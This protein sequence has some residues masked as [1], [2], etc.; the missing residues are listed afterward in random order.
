MGG[1]SW[2]MRSVLALVCLALAAHASIEDE[3]MGGVASAGM[4]EAENMMEVA[5]SNMHAR[6]EAMAQRA[7]E[8]M[9]GD[10]AEAVPRGKGVK[11]YDRTF[12]PEPGEEIT[13]DVVTAGDAIPVEIVAPPKQVAIPLKKLKKH[14]SPP[15]SFM[16]NLRSR[17]GKMR[18]KMMHKMRKMWGRKPRWIKMGH[19]GRHVHRRQMAKM[20]LRKALFKQC[21]EAKGMCPAHPCPMRIAKCLMKRTDE[22]STG[23]SSF[24]Q[25]L[26][27]LRKKRQ[28]ARRAFRAARRHCRKKFR[29]E[30][31]RKWSCVRRARKQKWRSMRSVWSSLRQASAPGPKSKAKAEDEFGIAKAKRVFEAKMAELK[32]FSKS[33]GKESKATLKA[34]KPAAGCKADADCQTGGDM[35]GYCKANGDCHCSAPFFGTN[36]KTCSLT[37][38][39]T[40]KT[41][42]CRDDADCQAGGDTKAYCKTPKANHH[43][44]PGNG[45]CRCGTGFSGTT[46]CHKTSEP[47][48]A[49][50]EK[51]SM[52]EG[53]PAWITGDVEEPKGEKDMGGWVM[54]AY[55]PEQQSRLNVD[56]MGRP[57]KKEKAAAKEE[58][59]EKAEEKTPSAELI[60]TTTAAVEKPVRSF[61]HMHF[62]WL[63][64]G[65]AL[66][67][68]VIGAVVTLKAR[69]RQQSLELRAVYGQ[70]MSE[71]KT[72]P[73][74][75]TAQAQ[76]LVAHEGPADSQV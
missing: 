13:V 73:M 65:L 38:T 7:N 11:S 17:L 39:P 24:L 30:K 41:P 4:A 63:F 28:A 43:T 12:H 34:G 71:P 3:I 31:R 67:I 60:S 46:S 25:S 59:K 21:S 50:E 70:A 2:R 26:K 55:P 47:K 69:R 36:G 56:E 15:R 18:H 37:C 45:M 1:G 14:F 54:R 75:L 66:L 51:S 48:V 64:L 5:Q 68:A 32:A 10:V 62:V 8:V 19:K 61:S 53:T 6:I 49:E 20:L 16:H 42:C 58:K 74:G 44:T 40:S 27:K 22:V 57:Q 33:L 35:G 9:A 29:G 23:C 76:V 52:S 72:K